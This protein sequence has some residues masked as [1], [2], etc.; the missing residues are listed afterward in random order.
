MYKVRIERRARKQLA[1]IPPPYFEGLKEAILDLRY[2]PR[3]SSCKK[4]KGLDAFRLRVAQYRT[5]YEIQDD[6][7]LVNVPAANHR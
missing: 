4:L 5:I 3:P 1:K 2:E 6:G 7:L